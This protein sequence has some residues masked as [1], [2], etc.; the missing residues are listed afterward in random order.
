ML[1]LIEVRHLY[2]SLPL[3]IHAVFM[4]AVKY[5]YVGAQINE[6]LSFGLALTKQPFQ[7]QRNADLESC[8]LLSE[9]LYQFPFDRHTGLHF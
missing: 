1:L 4:H 6:S 8:P 5:Y 3:L 2:L 9:L 7:E